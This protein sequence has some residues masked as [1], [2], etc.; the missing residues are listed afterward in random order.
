MEE[1]VVL[2]A[3]DKWG[4]QRAALVSSPQGRLSVITGK[5]RLGAGGGAGR[6]THSLTHSLTELCCFSCCR[7]SLG[8]NS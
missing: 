4:W 6:C 7:C 8:A 2:K 3:L 5:E 1:W